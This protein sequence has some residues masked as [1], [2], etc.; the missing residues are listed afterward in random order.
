MDGRAGGWRE[1][2]TGGRDG[3]TDGWTDGRTDG[4]ME[5]GRDVFLKLAFHIRGAQRTPCGSRLLHA[6]LT[7][8]IPLT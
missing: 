2:G 3:Q 6:F 7:V 1:G 4:R 8:A 5:G